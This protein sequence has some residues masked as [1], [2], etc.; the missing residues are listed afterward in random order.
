MLDYSDME[1]GSPQYESLRSHYLFSGLNQTEYATL[2]TQVT[3]LKLEKAAA[4]F[5]RNDNADSFFFVDSGQIELYVISATGQ[6]KTVEVIGAGGT[7]A[8]AVAFMREVK[9]PVTAAALV[10]STLCRIP[11][12]AYTKILESNFDACMRM[13]TDVSRRLHARVREID[14][15]T[16]Q[17]ASSRLA[18][19][20]LAHMQKTTEDE[21]I[22][23]FDVPKHVVA[24][25]LSIKPETLSRLLRNLVNDGVVTI[26][27]NE[28]QI[29]SLVRLRPYD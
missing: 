13:L 25:R 14:R 7:F 8:E 20:L 26:N 28:I 22:V 2:V 23:R 4:L 10:D 19:Y 11:N 27:D 3:V 17:N 12:A 1:I 5:H 9:Y 24:S 15:L 29:H 21:A 6:K 18:S 16:V